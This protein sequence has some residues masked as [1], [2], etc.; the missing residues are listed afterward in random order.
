[1]LADD[2]DDRGRPVGFG[3]RGLASDQEPK[4]LNS[5]ETPLFQKKRL[6]YGLSEARDAIRR[7]N[8]AVL[9]EGYFD[10][11]GLLGAGIEETTASM[12]TSLTAEHAEKLRRLCEAAAVCY[13]GDAAGRAATRSAVGLLLAQ[14][15]RVSVVRMPP[16]R[17]PYDLLREE[18]P[19]ALSARVEDAPDFLTWLLEEARPDEPTGKPPGPLCFSYE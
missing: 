6:L 3:G 2:R 7:R 5:P 1:M 9:V 4:Y 13:D 17:D 18:G 16:D 15:L 10:H 8:R 12:G 19:Q 14:G 11:L